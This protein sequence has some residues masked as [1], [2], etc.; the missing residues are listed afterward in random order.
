MKIWFAILMAFCSV[1]C[2]QNSTSNSTGPK[3]T[4]DASPLPA[5]TISELNKNCTSIDLISL[6]KE[7]NVSMNF[8]NPQ[9]VQY[10]VSFIT[11][12]KGIVAPGS[13]PEGRVSFQKNGEIVYD[14]DLYY[15]D[16]SNA[17]VWV[18][19]QAKV[20]NMNKISPEGIDFFKNFLKPQVKGPRDSSAQIT[21]K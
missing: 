12:E 5:E 11:D 9:A 18:D 13:K 1:G 20:L 2:K 7:V 15:S 16:G 8:D 19:M 21:P 4:M 14:A 10:V 3:S 17:M 6:K